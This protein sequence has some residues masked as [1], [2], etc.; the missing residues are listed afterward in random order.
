MTHS[1]K[2]DRTSCKLAVDSDLK[3]LPSRRKLSCLSTSVNFENQDKPNVKVVSTTLEEIVSKVEEEVLSNSSQTVSPDLSSLSATSHVDNLSKDWDDPSLILQP[4]NFSLPLEACFNAPV[5]EKQVEEI[6]PLGDLFAGM[7]EVVFKGIPE[8]SEPLNQ[9]HVKAK[10]KAVATATTVATTIAA[11][12][13][14]PTTANAPTATKLKADANSSVKE[15]GVISKNPRKISRKSKD[16]HQAK[17][18]QGMPLLHDIEVAAFNSASSLNYKEGD[19]FVNAMHILKPQSQS[20]YAKMMAEKAAQAKLIAE[21]QAAEAAKEEQYNPL[22]YCQ[23]LIEDDP[24]RRLVYKISQ[25]CN[26]VDQRL[27][28]EL[29]TVEL[30]KSLNLNPVLQGNITQSKPNTQTNNKVQNQ[31]PYT[32]FTRL[33]KQLYVMPY[34]TFYAHLYLVCAV[35]LYPFAPARFMSEKLSQHSDLFLGMMH[36]WILWRL[37]LVSAFK[38]D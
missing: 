6:N 3:K 8:K 27:Q 26:K 5:A 11:T 37:H 30:P 19:E 28:V 13:S 10:A 21:Q 9:A 29:A 33:A 4:Q 20:E 12:T 32:V 38:A 16:E 14:I 35:W 7:H 31:L 25:D 18:A 36:Y 15:D 24:S 34:Q 2:I 22:Q 17:S 23:M 1:L